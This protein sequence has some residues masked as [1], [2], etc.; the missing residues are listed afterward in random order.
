MNWDCF[1][2]PSPFLSWARIVWEHHLLSLWPKMPHIL[3]G[4][5]CCVSS[6]ESPSILFKKALFPSTK[7]E[8]SR[9]DQ[10][11]KGLGYL[12]FMHWVQLVEIFCSRHFWWKRLSEISIRKCPFLFVF[13]FSWKN[14][15]IESKS[16]FLP[17]GFLQL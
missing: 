16:W 10:F 2:Y 7:T 4:I 13:R 8:F 14:W 3:T 11:K 1:L 9:T 12:T 6:T 17:P 15:I 5:L